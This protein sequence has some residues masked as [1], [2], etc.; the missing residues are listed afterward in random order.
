[1]G[2]SSKMNVLFNSINVNVIAAN[3]GIFVG[4]NTQL[5]WNSVNK[6]NSGAGNVLGSG[7]FS[8]GNIN[9]L[10]DNDLI[11]TCTKILE[12]GDDDKDDGSDKTKN[13]P[14]SQN[15]SKE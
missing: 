9:V 12:N 7:N 1:M 2:K 14:E 4:S 10:Y 5:Y 15:N 13:K 3:S 8:T 6:L 11:D